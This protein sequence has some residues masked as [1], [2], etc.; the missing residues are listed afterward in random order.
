M[1]SNAKAGLKLLYRCKRIDNHISPTFY[2]ETLRSTSLDGL[3]VSK[4]LTPSVSGVEVRAGG[5]PGRDGQ[6]SARITTDFPFPMPLPGAPQTRREI[7]GYNQSRRQTPLLPWFPT[8]TQGGF[9]TSI[10]LFPFGP[11]LTC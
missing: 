2:C 6:A 10:G 1:C 7:V 8:L 9:Q 4:S 5:W 3:V 11:F